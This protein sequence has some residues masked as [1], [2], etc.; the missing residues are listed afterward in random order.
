MS[1]CLSDDDLE[2][3]VGQSAS[4]QE[5]SIPDQQE[6]LEE[7]AVGYQNSAEAGNLLQGVPVQRFFCRRD[8]G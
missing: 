4:E 5:Q 2:A 8:R 1:V 7:Y 6:A 3:F